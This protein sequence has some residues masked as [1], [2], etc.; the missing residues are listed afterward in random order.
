MVPQISYFYDIINRNAIVIKPKKPFLD[1]INKLDP[2]N[3]ITDLDE[4]TIYLIKEKDSNEEIE[5]WLKRNFEKIFQNELNDWHTYENDW[6]QK[7]T[8]KLF[9]EWFGYEIHSMVLDIEE[10]H[11]E[12]N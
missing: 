11:I 12:K 8:F 10:T 4:G 3:P 1:W 6:P 9:K 5:K 7:R 2:L